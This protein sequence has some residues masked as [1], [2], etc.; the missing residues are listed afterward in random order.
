MSI[1]NVRYKDVIKNSEVFIAT[2]IE[3]DS[4]P[5]IAVDWSIFI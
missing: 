1:T 4:C 2:T 5:K 3:Y